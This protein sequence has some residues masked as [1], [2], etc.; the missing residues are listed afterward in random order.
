MTQEV[1]PKF[2]KEFHESFKHAA[3]RFR[4]PYWDWAAKKTRSGSSTPKY[5]LPEIAKE[6]QIEVLS[7]DGTTTGFVDNPMHKFTMPGHKPMGSYGVTDVEKVPVI[8]NLEQFT[9]STLISYSSQHLLVQ[10]D[11]R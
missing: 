8:E 3:G 7:Y 4:F 2:P 5:D 6:P 9:S 1:I 11:G 10:A